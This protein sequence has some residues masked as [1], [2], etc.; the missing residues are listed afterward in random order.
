M[1][2]VKLDKR[3][4]VRFEHYSD[5]ELREYLNNSIMQLIKYQKAFK[6]ACEIIKM[7]GITSYFSEDK[8]Y[9]IYKLKQV[10]MLR[11]MEINI[12]SEDII[13]SKE[14]VIEILN[15][16]A[17]EERLNV[18]DGIYDD[19]DA[20]I[21]AITIRYSRIISWVQENDISPLTEIN[22]CVLARRLK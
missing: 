10:A 11:N 8:W 5:E 22:K 4:L 14:D 3:L 18:D 12:N 16:L 2:K 13:C 20:E 17:S 9:E 1:T 6:I 7:H 15:D 21:D 19:P